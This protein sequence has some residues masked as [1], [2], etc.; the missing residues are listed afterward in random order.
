MR[1]NRNPQRASYLRELS[2]GTAPCPSARRRPPLAVPGRPNNRPAAE[3][4][5]ARSG[6]SPACSPPA[7]T[8][9]RGAA[10]AGVSR[11]GGPR[12]GRLLAGTARKCGGRYLPREFDPRRSTRAPR[13]EATPQRSGFARSLARGRGGRSGPR[14]LPSVPQQRAAQAP[15]ARPAAE[16][17][18]SSPV[19]RSAAT[20]RAEAEN[21]HRVP[22]APQAAGLSHQRIG[23]SLRLGSPLKLIQSNHRAKTA[24]ANKPC[25]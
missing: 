21:T 3:R 4:S 15:A 2:R 13:P 7:P 6:T 16:M 14:A 8:S 9:W 22:T 24:L 19:H 18:R 10:G 11:V 5:P 25:P 12:G 17:I 20:L 1:G 23:E